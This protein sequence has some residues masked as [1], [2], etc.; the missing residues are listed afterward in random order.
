MQIYADSAGVWH[1]MF[2]STMDRNDRVCHPPDDS[3]GVSEGNKL[4][5][6]LEQPPR[7]GWL[8]P[9]GGEVPSLPSTMRIIFNKD[10]GSDDT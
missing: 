7:T 8:R 9:S 4:A 5:K 3:P 1:T 6:K 10:R 2:S